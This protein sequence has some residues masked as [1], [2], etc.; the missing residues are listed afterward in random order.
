M[1]QNCFTPTEIWKLLRLLLI[2]NFLVYIWLIANKWNFLIFHPYQ[3]RPNH[4]VNLKTILTII[5]KNS[6]FWNAKLY[7][8]YLG[9]LIANNLTWKQHSNY[10]NEK[11]IVKKNQYTAHA[12][13]YFLS[14]NYSSPKHA[15]FQISCYSHARYHKQFSTTEYFTVIQRYWSSTPF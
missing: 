7:I 3:K 15:L 1:T 13:P 14:S 4:Q 5:L 2:V 6:F 10:I 9:E 8:K 12:I 11:K